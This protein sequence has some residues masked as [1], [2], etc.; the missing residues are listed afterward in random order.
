MS[1]VSYPT[2]PRILDEPPSPGDTL[3]HYDLIHGLLFARILSALE[4]GTDWRK[5][6][7]TILLR[8]SDQNEQDVRRCW[9]AHVARAR[10]LAVEGIALAARGVQPSDDRPEDYPLEPIPEAL[11]A[12]DGGSPR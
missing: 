3:T 9:E 12:S 10:W 6:A 2:Y 4:A 1:L 5:G 8:D 7:R 11:L